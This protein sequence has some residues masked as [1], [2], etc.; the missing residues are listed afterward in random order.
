MSPLVTCWSIGQTVVGQPQPGPFSFTC[1][2]K[3]CLG[4]KTVDKEEGHPPPLSR[5]PPQLQFFPRVKDLWDAS[6]GCIMSALRRWAL[7]V[8]V[9]S[10]S[11]T[12]PNTAPG[13]A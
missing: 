5:P 1:L 11:L 7:V 2:R 8:P 4:P 13:C 6:G 9:A 12:Q 3:V 10:T